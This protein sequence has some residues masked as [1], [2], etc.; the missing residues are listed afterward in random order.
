MKQEGQV[1]PSSLT[2]VFEI[3]LAIFFVL[4]GEEFTRILYV[5]SVQVTPIH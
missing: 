5:C 4:F 1:G 3:T 2:W